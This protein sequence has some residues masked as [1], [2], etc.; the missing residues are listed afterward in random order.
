MSKEIQELKS[1]I[2]E[3]E[4][5]LGWLPKSGMYISERLYAYLIGQVR[6]LNLELTELEYNE[7]KQ[8]RKFINSN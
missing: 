4:G 7:R 3:L 2:S 8:L 6:A 1:Q 5:L